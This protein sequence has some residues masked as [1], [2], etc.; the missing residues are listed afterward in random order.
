MSDGYGYVATY[1]CRLC[2]ETYIGAETGNEKI[3][4]TGV[5]TLS[6]S[7]QYYPYGSGIGVYRHD[8]HH[9]A[10]GSIGFGDFCGF[11]KIK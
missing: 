5:I 10:N 4:E 9:C 11:K 2:G 1:K 3:A 6:A 8:I 7:P